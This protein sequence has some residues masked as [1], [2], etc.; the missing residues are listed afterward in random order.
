MRVLAFASIFSGL[1]TSSKLIKL[2]LLGTPLEYSLPFPLFL[3]W[4]L[5]LWGLQ[6]PFITF[7]LD[8]IFLVMARII[9]VPFGIGR[10]NL[11]T[12]DRPEPVEG[13]REEDAVGSEELSSRTSSGSP[14][15]QVGQGEGTIVAFTEH[16]G[17]AQGDQGDGAQVEDN[18]PAFEDEPLHAVNTFVVENH[19]KAVS[20]VDANAMV[21]LVEVFRKAPYVHI[22]QTSKYDGRSLENLWGAIQLPPEYRLRMPIVA[23]RILLGYNI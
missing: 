3:C 17:G 9:R 18:D 6:A 7:F 23:E 20:T 4:L 8:I 21:G 13:A 19:K 5:Y 15:D 11:P 14:R 12:G 16:E 1:H 22:T 10:T 2:T